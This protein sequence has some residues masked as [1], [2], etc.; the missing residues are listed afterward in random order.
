[1]KPMTAENRKRLNL[2]KEY[3]TDELLEEL[4]LDP[5]LGMPAKDTILELF[6]MIEVEKC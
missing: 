3:W 4:A 1:M 2:W 6:E 5:I